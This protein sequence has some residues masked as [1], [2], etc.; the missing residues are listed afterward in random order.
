MLSAK[1]RSLGT[2]RVLRIAV[3]ASMCGMF[4]ACGGTTSLRKLDAADLAQVKIGDTTA[5][6][7]AKLGP[8]EDIQARDRFGR[9]VWT[10]DYT[11][12]TQVRAYREASLYFDPATGRLRSIETGVDWDYYPDAYGR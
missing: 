11:D 6:V 9:E 8:A 10:Y 1:T 2:L 5:E 4:A 7:R 12:R 3:I